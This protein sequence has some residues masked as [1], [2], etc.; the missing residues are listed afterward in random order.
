MDGQKLE[1]RMVK[2]NT[3]ECTRVLYSGFEP[4]DPFTCRMKS[5]SR[6]YGGLRLLL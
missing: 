3:G 1:C 6:G 4:D 2:R 5:D